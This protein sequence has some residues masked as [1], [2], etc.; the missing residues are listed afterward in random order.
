MAALRSTLFDQVAAHAAAMPQAPALVGTDGTVPYAA[1]ER[2][3]RSVAAGLAARG[4]GRGDVVAVQLPNTAAFVELL[5][6]ATALGAVVQTVHMTYR[7]AELVALLGHSRARVFVGLD[8]V[9][10]DAPAATVLALRGRADAPLPAL[11]TVVAVGDPPDGA[12][13][14]RTLADAAPAGTL[15]A[16][17]PDAPYVLLYTSGT[18]ASPKGVPTTARRFLGNAADAAAEFVFG[19][20]DVLLAA[21]PFT[22]LYGLFVLQAGLLSGAALS[23]LPAFSP[24]ALIETVRRDR[25]TALF[26]GPAHF[27]PLLDQDAMSRS[28]FAPVRLLCLSGTAVPPALARAV[29]ARLSGGE[30]IQLWG[31][32]E[33]QAGAYGR[34][35]DPPS[36]RLETAGRAA[37]QTALRV[38]DEQGT[39]RA[40]GVEGRLQVR[41]AAVFDGY[42]DN[43]A[44]SAAAF[45][46]G[47]FDTGDTAVIRP[48][49]ALVLTGRV[50]ELIDRGG[51]KFNP[52]DV[53][54]LLDARPGVGRCVLAPMPDPVLGERACAFVVPDGTAEVTLASLTAALDAAGVAKFKW[55]ERLEF[56]DE[57]PMTPTQKVRRSVLTDL[58]KT[59]MTR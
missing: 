32:S 43:P 37:P 35:G 40:R 19:P 52:V 56:V 54:V 6:G 47:W 57:L 17:G 14:W 23:L 3:A 20:G 41:G 11:S 16:V 31:M 29:E 5:L 9:R 1:L 46:D 2:R 42:L 7:R 12:V 44:A 25:V 45:D 10:D 13:G 26:A 34:P 4:V 28:D 59:R 48:D 21:A 39:E 58:V 53:E 24:A 15:P 51:V 50:K 49:D 8:R 18:T 55:P 33:L 36:L 38:V 27:K 30:V 22:H